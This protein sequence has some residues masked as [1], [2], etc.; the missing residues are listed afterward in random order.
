MF[1][2][3]C[4]LKIQIFKYKNHVKKKLLTMVITDI[5]GGC[6]PSRKVGRKQK[7]EIFIIFQY[8]DYRAMRDFWKKNI[9]NIYTLKIVKWLKLSKKAFVA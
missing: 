7:F 3:F 6:D 8:C 2:I 4:Y 5:N 1:Y 9:E